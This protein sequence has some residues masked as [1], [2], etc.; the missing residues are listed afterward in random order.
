[1]TAREPGTPSVRDRWRDLVIFGVGLA[2]L[3]YETVVQ[4]GERPTLLLVFSA[5]IGLP[6]FFRAD[7]R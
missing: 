1:M 3:C 7:G 4:R 5:M 2:G 6:A